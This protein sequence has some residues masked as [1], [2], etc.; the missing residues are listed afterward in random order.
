MK[1]IV[2]TFGLISGFCSVILM[3]VFL[4]LCLSGKID[5][6][7]GEIIGYTSM[8]VSFLMIFFGIRSYRD[9]VAGGSVTF[10][11]AFKVGLLITLVASAVYVV[12]WEIY[13]FNFD[14]GFAEKYSA[15]VIAKLRESGADAAKIAAEEKKMAEFQVWYRNPLLNSGMTFLE[16]FPV[17]LVMTLVSAAILKRR[18]MEPALA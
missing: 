1:K 3:A 6:E 12:S 16:I 5:F 18:P 11:R 10:G 4:P 15:H 14:T 8:V 17:G 2:L 13:Y 9:N 7:Y